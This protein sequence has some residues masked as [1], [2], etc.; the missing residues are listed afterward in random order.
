MT[1]IN[2]IPT[3][4][5]ARRIVQCPGDAA[6][7]VEVT[8]QKA[9]FDHT[10]MCMVSDSSGSL[11][12]D[13]VIVVTS[14]DDNGIPSVHYFSVATGLPLDQGIYSSLVPC[15]LTEIDYEIKEFCDNGTTPF[16]RWFA[17]KS[18][19]AGTPFIIY[20]SF[21]TQM[22]GYTPYTVTG[23]VSVGTCGAAN[24]FVPGAVEITG[25]TPAS[26]LPTYVSSITITAKTDDVNVSFDGGVTDITIPE[27]GSF[28]WGSGDGFMSTSIFVITGA[29]ASSIYIIHWEALPVT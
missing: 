8:N 13:K 22:D 25:I 20:S 1:C 3:E 10:I 19:M 14:Y 24:T 26:G 27:G 5:K 6:M 2:G 21:D 28:T 9:E 23:T 7:R 17:V 11:D 29:S 4:V 18:E 12:P 16:L 15:G